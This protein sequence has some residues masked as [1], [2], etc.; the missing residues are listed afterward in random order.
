MKI[1]TPVTNRE[2]FMETGK[3]IVSK[4]D[5]KGIITYVNQT[6]VDISGF[7]RDELLGKNHN[8]VRHPEMPPEAFKDLWN[9]AKLGLPW[10]G[11][12]KN[13]CKNGDFYWVEAYVTPLRENGQ[14]IGY[15]SVRNIPKKEDVQAA[16]KLYQAL[17]EGKI[18]LGKAKGFKLPDLAFMRRMD[19]FFVALFL[20]MGLNAARGFMI[21]A[22]PLDNIAAA[23][24][25]LAALFVVVT[26][27]ML[28]RQINTFL[29]QTRH[30]L[31]QLAEGNFQFNIVI[32]GKDEFAR[33][34]MELES[35]RINLRAII[36]DIFLAARNVGSGARNT[37][38]ELQ[39]LA[40]RS[41]SQLDSVSTTNAAVEQMCASIETAGE[42]TRASEEA[43]TLTEKIVQQGNQQMAAT[44]SSVNRIVEV[45]NTSRGT[46]S[47]LNEAIQHIGTLTETIKEIADQTNLLALNAAIEA[48]RAGEQGRGFAVVADEVRKLA[49][50]TASSTVDIT[51]KV[52]SIR[53]TTADAVARID[54]AVSEVEKGTELIHASSA[55]LSKI[56]AASNKSIAMSHDI[57]NLLREQSSTAQLIGHS[58]AQISELAENN[59]A[60]IS[61]T[62]QVTT[63]LAYTASELNLLLKHFERSI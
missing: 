32:K 26:R 5:L 6:F 12:V 15:M 59:N 22:S 39:E 8:I 17:R 9:T 56:L 10:R 27:I 3:P 18:T 48:A 11:M 62:S 23:L 42:H 33:T 28:N 19:I 52:S 46:I 54:Q 20:I 24:S 1:N 7:S 16:E 37:E 4:T 21:A 51:D 40:R 53:A 36:A 57:S 38:T 35:M 47:S 2:V 45:V 30:A 41:A 58:M 31:N 29:S 61:N 43:N 25:A 60:S 49:E 50:R 55:S 34:L 44:I 63:N 13:R 14:T